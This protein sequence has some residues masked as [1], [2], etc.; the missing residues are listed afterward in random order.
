MNSPGLGMLLLRDTEGREEVGWQAV[1]VPEAGA[2]A[3]AA[4]EGVGRLR[5]RLS[6][7]P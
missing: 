5:S 3:R 7:R 1:G 4:L 6:G 2:G